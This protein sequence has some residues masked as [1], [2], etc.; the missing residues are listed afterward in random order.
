MSVKCKI[1]TFADTPTH[2]S[3]HTHRKCT[4]GRARF[5]V[6][7]TQKSTPVVAAYTH[8]HTHTHTHKYA[9]LIKEK[10]EFTA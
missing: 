8:T 9:E 10:Q 2:T 5:G 1:P 3:L 4:V 7:S 6:F